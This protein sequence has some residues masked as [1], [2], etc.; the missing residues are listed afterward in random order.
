MAVVFKAQSLV[1][2]IKR[3]LLSQRRKINHR[4]AL[5]AVNFLHDGGMQSYVTA[6]R[7][8]AQVLDVDYVPFDCRNMRQEDIFNLLGK[9][10][11]GRK[12]DGVILHKPFPRRL[13]PFLLFERLDVR[14]DIE[15]VHPYSRGM[16]VAGRPLFVPPTVLSVLEVLKQVNV[17]LRG[18]NVVIVGFSEILGKPLSTILADA[19][20]TVSVV[21][22]GTYE[23]G[24][25][26]FYV[27][28]ADILISAVGKPHLIK[29]EWV[30][31]GAVVIDVGISRKG[32]TIVGD[33][34]FDRASKK[35]SFITPVPGGV[36]SLTVAFLY[37]NLLVAAYA[38]ENHKITG[39]LARGLVR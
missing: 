34:E 11:R 18:K 8:W 25:L 4:P 7:R 21:H 29:G 37:S 15:G 10:N 28:H 31:E 9:L 19:L 3:R 14:K 2:K 16:L 20:A 38:K 33:V 26:E 35:A 36:G 6:Q 1:T 30:K 13:N 39:S 24:Y 22:I 5:A 23:A 32:N 27:R 17:P 12:F